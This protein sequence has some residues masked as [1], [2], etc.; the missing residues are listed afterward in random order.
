MLVD[1]AGSF[2]YTLRLRLRDAT[3]ELYG[4]I[5]NKDGMDFFRV[6]QLSFKV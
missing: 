5:F 4:L 2:V 6:G 3:G 1:E